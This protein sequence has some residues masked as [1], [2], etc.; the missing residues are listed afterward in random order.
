MRRR[1]NEFRLVVR[2]TQVVVDRAWQI[3]FFDLMTLTED[4]GVLDGVFELPHVA[5]KW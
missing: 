4:Y 5:G 3:A 1:H 2:P